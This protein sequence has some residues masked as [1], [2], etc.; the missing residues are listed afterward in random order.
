[1]PFDIEI[2]EQ[3]NDTYCPDWGDSFDDTIDHITE[4]FEE[5]Y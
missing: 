4:N 2:D 1:M 3:E 5:A